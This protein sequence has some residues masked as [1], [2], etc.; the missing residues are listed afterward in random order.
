MN[1]VLQLGASIDLSDVL[2]SIAV[3]KLYRTNFKFTVL[4]FEMEKLFGSFHNGRTHA[5][6]NFCTLYCLIK[7]SHHV[8][9]S[10]GTHHIPVIFLRK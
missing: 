6:I 3:T 5:P 10:F 9:L 7:I 2:C 1:L 8:F 4:R